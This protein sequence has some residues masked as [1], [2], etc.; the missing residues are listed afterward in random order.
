MAKIAGDV[1]YDLLILD[2]ELPG[3]SGI[4]LVRRTRSL[5]HRRNTPVVIFS[6]CN[7][8]TAARRTKADAFLRKPDD[9]P[10]IVGTISRLFSA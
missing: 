9:T 4:E 2:Y 3:A 5:E 10:A 6:G 7:V 8:R 1:T